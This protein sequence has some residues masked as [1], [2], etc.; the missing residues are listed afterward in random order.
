MFVRNTDIIDVKMFVRSAV[1]FQKAA[2]PMW[3]SCFTPHRRWTR[4]FRPSVVTA[5]ILLYS[6]TCAAPAFGGGQGFRTEHLLED[7]YEKYGREFGSISRDKYLHLAQHLR[8]AKPGRHILESKRPD[9]V[10]KF[11]VKHGYFGEYYSD[12]GIRTFFIP[13]D[14]I[15]YF[16][17]QLR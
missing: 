16:Q 17:M 8:D 10:V 12:G 7:H 4:T 9:G 2:S 6:L 13:P 3:I 5:G 1:A 14:G 15:R 11:D